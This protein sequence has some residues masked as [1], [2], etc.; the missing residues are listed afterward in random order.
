M[1]NPFF[2]SY[3]S[4]DLFGKLIFISLLGLSIFSWYV[5]VQKALYHRKARRQSHNFSQ[6]FSDHEK[7]P[8]ALEIKTPKAPNPF[9]TIYQALQSL[10][11]QVLEKNRL[12]SREKTSFLSSADM[13]FVGSQVDHLI[14]RQAKFLEKNLFL[15]STITT[16]APFLGLLGTVWGSLETLSALRSHHTVGGSSPVLEGLSLA[17]ATTVCGLLVAIPSLV[18]YAYLRSATRDFASEMGDFGTRV[19]TAIEM[20]YRKVDS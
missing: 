9:L 18:G 2:A 8:L 4:S 1:S 16:L 12:H 13:E 10:C 15:L 5:I 6:I 19:L 20:H 7:V 11:L 3:V 17:L 14:A